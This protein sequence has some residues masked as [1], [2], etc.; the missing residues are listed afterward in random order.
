MQATAVGFGAVLLWALLAL[1]TVGSAPTPPLLLNTI[2]FLIGGACG[3]VWTA[4]SGGLGVLRQV[5]WRV[6]AFGTLG[7]FG[8]H[9]L[10]FSALRLA[11]AAE[12]GLIAYLWPLLIVLMSGLLPGERLRRGH[13][14]GAVTGF[15]GA[16]LII[17]GGGQGFQASHGAGYALAL[18]CAFTWSSYSVL[19]RR[20]GD[21]PTQSVTVF[22]LGAAALS[23]PLHLAF[24]ETIWPADTISWVSTALLGLGPVGLAFFVWDIGVKHG[25]IQLLGAA[26]YAAPLLSTCILVLAGVAPLS[27]T[28]GLAAI[29]ITGGAALAA[30]ASFGSTPRPTSE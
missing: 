23:M 28:L 12:A 17:S 6:Y 18:I 24:E 19:S 9:A 14:L 25:D 3:L 5:S 8:Y 4:F 7:L 11:P 27:A 22:C 10:Y 29:L 21:A 20:V 1:L 16:A 26:S 2:C 30:Y 13:V 15:V